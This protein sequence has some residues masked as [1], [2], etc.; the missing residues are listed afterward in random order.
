[1]TV[2]AVTFEVTDAVLEQAVREECIAFA[3]EHWKLRDALL[4]AASVAIFVGAVRGD[5]HWLWWIAGLPPAIFAQLLAGWLLAYLGL[6]AISAKR[7]D[8]LAHR[9][10]TVEI[11]GPQAAKHS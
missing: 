7:L 1:M 5:A 11:S 4:T 2:D 6:P 9:Q 10:I 3:R 8:H